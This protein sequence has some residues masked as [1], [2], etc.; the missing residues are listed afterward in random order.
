MQKEWCKGKG[1]LFEV[2]KK[3]VRLRFCVVH[4]AAL[5]AVGGLAPAGKERQ[6]FFDAPAR[7]DSPGRAVAACWPLLCCAPRGRL[8]CQLSHTCMNLCAWLQVRSDEFVARPTPVNTDDY[9]DRL[10]L[11]LGDQCL[12]PSL[13]CCRSAAAGSRRA[14]LLRG[15][16]WGSGRLAFLQ[17]SD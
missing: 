6:Q 1:D 10:L 5:P 16:K 4:D 15:S 17:T 3:T 2:L 7:L 13:P 12:L 9:G 8:R 14:G 11:L